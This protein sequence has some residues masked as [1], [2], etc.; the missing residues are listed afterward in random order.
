MLISEPKIPQPLDYDTDSE[1]IWLIPD[2]D[3]RAENSSTPRAGE[4]RDRQRS[5]P[6]VDQ[7]AENSSTP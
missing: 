2:V 6:D 1:D 3:Q 4:V 7:R 5:R